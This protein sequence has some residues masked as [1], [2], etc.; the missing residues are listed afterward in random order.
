M[1][2]EWWTPN[3]QWKGDDIFGSAANYATVFKAQ[4]NQDPTYYSAAASAAGVVLQKAI[5][6]ANSLDVDAVRQAMHNMNTQ[7]F[8]GPIKFNDQGV[9]VGTNSAAV[10]QIQNGQVVVVWPKE[11]QQSN[12][13]F[14]KP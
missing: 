1:G 13:I 14:P 10:S 8:W 7:T 4:Y 12:P 11:L 6:N 5:E 9:N 2:G 3:M